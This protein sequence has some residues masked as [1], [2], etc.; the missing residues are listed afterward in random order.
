MA[1]LTGDDAHAF[2]EELE[3]KNAE[4]RQV[5]RDEAKREAVVRGKEPF[6]YDKLRSIAQVMYELTQNMSDADRASYFEE[7]YYVSYPSMMSLEELAEHVN[8]VSRWM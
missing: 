8:E 7:L 3:R 1:K 6:S 4:H 2:V 5:A